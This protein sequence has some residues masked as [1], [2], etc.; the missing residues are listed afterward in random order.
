MLSKFLDC[1]IKSGN[2]RYGSSS[3]RYESGSDRYDRVQAIFS[4]D[5][6][7][8]DCRGSLMKAA[9]LPKASIVCLH[10]HCLRLIQLYISIMLSYEIFSNMSRVCSI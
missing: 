2:D 1:P 10:Q 4:F 7:I 8:E 3:D 6:R 9:E 5:P